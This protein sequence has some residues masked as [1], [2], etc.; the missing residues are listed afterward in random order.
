MGPFAL[1]CNEFGSS[2]RISFTKEVIVRLRQIAAIAFLFFVCTVSSAYAQYGFGDSHRDFEIAPFVGG[3]F[4]GS[5]NL[6]TTTCSGATC[7][8]DYMNVN[9][10]YDYGV[11]GDVS[12]WPGSGLEAEFMWNHQPT[13]LDAHSIITGNSTSVGDATL[14]TYQWGLLYAFR[15]ESKFR[16]FIAGGA[17]FTHYTAPKANLPFGNGFSY[18]IGGGAKYFFDR[19]FGVRLDVRFLASRTTYSPGLYCDPF[20]GFCYQ[21]TYA[22]FAHQGTANAGLIFRF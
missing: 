16:P 6:N 22:N 3:R 4:G 1:V 2:G 15:P 17:G 7:N 18:S 21:T 9:S 12:L 8:F 10:S 20:F 14:N 13:S 11:M 5:I 19:H